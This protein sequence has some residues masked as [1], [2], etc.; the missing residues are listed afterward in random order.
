MDVISYNFANILAPYVGAK[1]DDLPFITNLSAANIIVETDIYHFDGG[2]REINVSKTSL[3]TGVK[4]ILI[5]DT[6]IWGGFIKGFAVC[7]NGDD[8]YLVGTGNGSDFPTTGSNTSLAVWR[9]KISTN[10]MEV[11]KVYNADSTASYSSG[12]IKDDKIYIVGVS[13]PNETNK[14]V[15]YDIYTNTFMDKATMSTTREQCSTVLYK[16]Y[17]YVFGGFN[18]SQ[19]LKASEKYDITN[20]VWSSIASTPEKVRCYSNYGFLLDGEINFFTG[21]TNCRITYNPE[22]NSYSYK[23]PAKSDLGFNGKMVSDNKRNVYFY[24]YKMVGG[25]S[26]VKNLISTLSI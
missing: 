22:T 23:L 25:K 19:E 24:N 4:T 18:G 16:N 3:E 14:L 6:N 10:T 12:G 2:Y 21:F 15:E 20:N 26:L 1:I 9:Y 11:R 8:I 7:E 17:L 13:D 5:Q